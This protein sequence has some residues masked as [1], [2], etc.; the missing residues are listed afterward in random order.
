MNYKLEHKQK[1]YF[2]FDETGILITGAKI[3]SDEAFEK[4]KN[5]TG[6]ISMSWFTPVEQIFSLKTNQLNGH[7]TL[8]KQK[9]DGKL[10]KEIL[11]FEESDQGKMAAL[12]LT[13]TFGFEKTE[14][15]EESK[16]KIALEYLGYA[17]L[18]SIFGWLL[19][20]SALEFEETG[21][22]EL[23]ASGRK[24]G[25]EM[26]IKLAAE[27]LGLW[28]CIGVVAVAT[29]FAIFKL[30]KR[31]RSPAQIETYARPV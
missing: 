23:E 30:V 13:E 14:N 9:D 27:N 24:K 16:G 5:K 31:L 7:V 17:A 11:R 26:I 22:I 6:W 12:M 8:F 18:I 4:K 20:K 10:K 21:N 1:T 28:G 3:K 15:V 2:N 19:I 25:A 29:A